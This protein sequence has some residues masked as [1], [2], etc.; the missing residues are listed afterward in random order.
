M[1]F[2]NLIIYESQ[3]NLPLWTTR[4]ADATYGR[5][6]LISTHAGPGADPPFR[7]GEPLRE[8]YLPGQV[9]PIRLGLLNEPQSGL[10]GH[11]PDRERV[12]QRQKRAV[13]RGALRH[14]R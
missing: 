11:R 1:P 14:L 13:L 4:S 12:Q 8:S 9:G 7:S 3:Q 2:H 6:G 5:Q 10:L